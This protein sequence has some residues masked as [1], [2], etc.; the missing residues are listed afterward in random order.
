METI[1]NLN[2]GSRAHTAGLDSIQEKADGHI[3]PN[4]T[5][6]DFL[7]TEA[8]YQFLMNAAENK[9]EMIQMRE[10][11]KAYA[12]S[13]G[14][15][16]FIGLWNAYL[17]GH[18]A[19]V[20]K[21][22]GGVAL[23][24]VTDFDGQELELSSGPY[25]CND[26]GIT[27]VDRYGYEKIVCLHP[28]MPV[29]RLVNVDTGEE[30]IEIAF[31]KGYSWR[32]IVVP[33]SVVASG[34]SILQLADKGIV[35]TSENAKDLSAYLMQIE[36][37]NYEQ[38]PEQMSVSRLGWL[39]KDRFV[40]F[41]DNV[42]F[43][44]DENFRQMY[45]AVRS[46]G[47]YSKWLDAMR[48]LRAERGQ[49]RIFLAASFASVLIKPLGVLPF[50]VH[51]YGTTEVGKSVGL[52]VAA[53]VWADPEIGEYVTTFNS[54]A[55][56]QEM[57][58]TFLNNLPMCIDELQIKDAENVRD[59]DA[60]IYKLCEGRGK[61]RG[62]KNGGLQ[63]SGSWRNCF[64]STGERPI[65][66]HNSKGGA[67][68]RSIEFECD[69]PLFP[70]LP[71]LCDII[72]ENFGHAGKHFLE[73]L[74]SEGVMDAVKQ[75][76]KGFASELQKFKGMDKQAAAIALILATD[77]ILTKQMFKDSNYLTVED[78]IDIIKT[79]EDVSINKRAYEYLCA[80]PVRFQ[81]RFVPDKFNEY[82]GECWGKV[83]GDTIYI[84]KSVFD[85]EM[86][87]QGYSSVLFLSW[88][89]RNNKLSAAKDCNGRNTAVTRINGKTVRC[90]AIL[91][92][93]T[94]EN[95]TSEQEEK[96]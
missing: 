34:N 82:K 59:F 83:D 18:Q 86:D 43:D 72:K 16:G 68:N 19:Q 63:Q 75:L 69:K 61:A 37:L 84:I 94:N 5:Q 78:F 60:I 58:A 11:M 64:I 54:T 85:R 88:A 79:K 27:T 7:Y 21:R 95:G 25:I 73:L 96:S 66:N 55:V 36:Q 26:S 50:F 91:S 35:V 89:K 10:K 46:E 28:V 14:V 23:S 57:T 92:D 32:R 39:G 74:F 62:S 51:G 44:G 93:D 3:I 41:T 45:K 48:K 33:K 77:T 8:P 30:R 4:F 67:L 13:V 90:V 80:L 87:E 24:N 56:G 1:P 31:K 9:F 70:D 15:K 76:H 38:I 42:I 71:G 17:E 6:Y 52:M 53:S 2:D 12:A 29:R 22:G 20:K 49:G 47:D 40:P 81:S 65:T